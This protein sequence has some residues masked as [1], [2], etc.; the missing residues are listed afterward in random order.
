LQVYNSVVDVMYCPLGD[1]PT[2]WQGACIC[3]CRL[4]YVSCR[5]VCSGASTLNHR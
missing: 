3:M 5:T 4:K 1:R 2:T